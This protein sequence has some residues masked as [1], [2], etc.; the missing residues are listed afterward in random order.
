MSRLL[1]QPFRLGGMAHTLGYLW[2]VLM[3]I[4]PQWVELDTQDVEPV[5]DAG[6]PPGRARRI[7]QGTR[8]VLVEGEPGL[9]GATADAPQWPHPEW[10]GANKAPLVVARLGQTPSLAVAVRLD[11][12][13][14]DAL[15]TGIQSV[16]EPQEPARQKKRRLQSA[17]SPL[18]F[19]PCSRAMALQI[20]HK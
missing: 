7:R 12:R 10:S 9:V 8:E 6:S 3:E 18:L 5:S 4:P 2:E 1:L 15:R 17:R 11:W 19:L 13:C 20:R 16:V 14:L